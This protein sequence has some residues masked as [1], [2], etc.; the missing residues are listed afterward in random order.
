MAAGMVAGTMRVEVGVVISNGLCEEVV[1]K[2]AGMVTGT[3]TVEVGEFV[4]NGVCVRVAVGPGVAFDS[5]P[6]IKTARKMQ[7]LKNSCLF[8]FTIPDRTK[9]YYSSL[10][11]QHF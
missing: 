6:L 4:S 1:V 11:P 8:I 9:G 2:A 10:F 3:W 7:S 5:Q